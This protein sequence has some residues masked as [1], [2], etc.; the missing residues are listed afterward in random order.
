M[1]LRAYFRSPITSIGLPSE[2]EDS[3]F[4]LNNSALRIEEPLDRG[5]WSSYHLKYNEKIDPMFSE[6]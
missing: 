6:C 5:L 1:S 2:H 4:P 3:S